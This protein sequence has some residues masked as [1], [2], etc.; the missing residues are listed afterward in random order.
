MTDWLG[1]LWF[2]PNGLQAYARKGRRLSGIYVP[3]WTFDARTATDRFFDILD[4]PNTITER[5]AL[6]WL[7]CRPA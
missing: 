3:Y 2:A 7:P 4:A 5:S 6:R 1:R